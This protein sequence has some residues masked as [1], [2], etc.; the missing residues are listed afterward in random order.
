MKPSHTHMH[1]DRPVTMKGE[2]VNARR[3]LTSRKGRN[4]RSLDLRSE[5]V[6]HAITLLP[7]KQTFFSC[8][9][10]H[11]MCIGIGSR[12]TANRA[13]L[14]CACCVI[15]ILAF[16]CTLLAQLLS[17][18]SHTKKHIPLKNPSCLAV[19]KVPTNIASQGKYQSTHY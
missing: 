13:Y 18:L 5:I 7:H 11:T 12:C 8:M 1:N 10:T 4:K 16:V 17:Q 15:Y 19:F 3:D 14:C 6:I 9:F 2:C